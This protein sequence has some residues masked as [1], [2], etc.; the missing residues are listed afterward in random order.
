VEVVRRPRTVE[1][2]E[3]ALAEKEAAL[4]ALQSASGPAGLVFSGRLNLE[5]VQARRIVNVP[6][7]TQSGLKV[8]GGEG[9]RAGTWALAVVRV[10]NLP[11][12]KSWEPGQARLTRTVDA[13]AAVAPAPG[14]PGEARGHLSDDAAL[15]ARHHHLGPRAPTETDS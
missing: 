1:A 14:A 15:R 4:A 9:Y 10:R 6:T 7:G 11:D 3:V 2:L 8:P 5:G 13:V 12:Q